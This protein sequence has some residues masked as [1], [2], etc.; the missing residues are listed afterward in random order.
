MLQFSF[1]RLCEKAAGLCPGASVTSYE[2]KEGEFDRAFV[3]TMDTGRRIV[4]KV[5]YCFGGP[6]MLQVNTEVATIAYCTSPEVA[7]VLMS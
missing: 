5:P 1:P 3:F 7:F 6:R 4:A 2:K